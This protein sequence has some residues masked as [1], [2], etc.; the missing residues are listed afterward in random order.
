L[1][2]YYITQNAQTGD[3]FVGGE[4]SKPEDLLTSDDSKISP[5][6]EA[7]L[8]T[9]LPKIF[10]RGWKDSE[11][12]VVRKIWSGVMG[13]TLD[14]MPLVGQLPNG[15]TGRE[16]DGEWI[17]AGYNGMG[18][19]LCWGCGEAVAKMMLGQNNE[20]QEWFPSS[21]LI[22]QNRLDN[23]NITLESAIERFFGREPAS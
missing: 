1:N 17:A 9:I 2:F 22:T 5:L 20:V 23:P 3:V 16:G 15:M 11:A 12:P 18:M 14:H 4:R 8:R 19:P 10:R 13:F 7:N 21:F 6:S